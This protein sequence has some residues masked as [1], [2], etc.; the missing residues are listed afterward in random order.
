MSGSLVACGKSDGGSNA[1]VSGSNVVGTYKYESGTGTSKP[2]NAGGMGMTLEVHDD[3]TLEMKSSF[4][5]SPPK[6]I[7]S[8]K[9][10][11]DG[12]KMTFSDAKDDAN[13]PDPTQTTGT[14]DG[15]K[16]TISG[17]EGTITY[18]KQ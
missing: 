3:G 10:V 15:D 6:V 14:V 18:V 12:D 16:I 7:W 2:A 1:T 13:K 4:E 17:A 8:A 9:Y 11:V 5:G